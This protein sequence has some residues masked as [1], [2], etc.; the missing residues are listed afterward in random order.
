MKRYEC[1]ILHD[2]S[3][4]VYGNYDQYNGGFDVAS[5]SCAYL[6]EAYPETYSM[7]LISGSRSKSEK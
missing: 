1:W 5:Y 6:N 7:V 2:D 4:N 3:G